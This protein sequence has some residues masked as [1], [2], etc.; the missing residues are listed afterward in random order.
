MITSLFFWY[1]FE[2]NLR[3]FEKFDDYIAIYSLN[4]GIRIIEFEQLDDYIAVFSISIGINITEFEQ[5]D[6]YITVLSIHIYFRKSFDEECHFILRGGTFA[7][8]N[9]MIY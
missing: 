4:I 2:K 1:R 9:R 7:S 5:F 8:L 3:E 6:D